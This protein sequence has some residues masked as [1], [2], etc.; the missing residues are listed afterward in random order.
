MRFYIDYNKNDD[1]DEDDNE[2]S[3]GY[4]IKLKEACIVSFLSSVSSIE[5][6]IVLQL[7]L[8]PLFNAR[9]IFKFFR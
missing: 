1:D 9:F 2:K 5:R 7:H 8:I 6:I 3:F 4:N